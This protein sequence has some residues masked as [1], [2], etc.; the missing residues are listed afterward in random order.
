MET[1]GPVLLFDGECGLCV[2]CVKLLLAFDRK[3]HLK[4][5]SLQGETAQAFLRERGL[6]TDDFESAI[7]VAD[8]ANRQ[9]EKALFKTDALLAALRAVGGLWRILLV[10]K[11]I[12]RSWRDMGYDWIAR[13]RRQ[14][15]GPVKWA[16]FRVL[17]QGNRFLP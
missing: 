2:R 9:E 10:F 13:R 15:F 3:R 8:W 7:F 12:P 4:F 11:I 6:P 14:L 5:T 17:G 16:D 1:T